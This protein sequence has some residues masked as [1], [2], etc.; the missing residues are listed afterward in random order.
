MC[1]CNKLAGVFF[2]R[3]VIAFGD[4]IHDLVGL[5]VIPRS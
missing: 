1:M 3:R 5:I 4:K 2:P